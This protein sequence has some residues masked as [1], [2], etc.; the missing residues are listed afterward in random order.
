MSDSIQMRKLINILQESVRSPIDPDQAEQLLTRLSPAYRKCKQADLVDE[1]SLGAT[2]A[3]VAIVIGGEP[4]S[5]VGPFDYS[6]AVEM[7]KTIQQDIERSYEK[8]HPQG[9]T[10]GSGTIYRLT[11][12]D[13]SVQTA[14]SSDVRPSQQADNENLTADKN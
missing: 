7:Q 10:D 6:G 13:I 3:F 1:G 4:V 12:W 2:I 14:H 5:E 9:W 11:D 8:Y